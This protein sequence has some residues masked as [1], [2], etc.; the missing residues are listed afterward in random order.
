M[1]KELGIAI[2]AAG[3]GTRLRSHRAKVLFEI[4]GATLLEHVINTARMLVEAKDIHVIIGHQ[5]DIVRERTAHIGVKYVL[6]A[7]Q[8]G[9][10]HAIRCARKQLSQYKEILVLSGDAPLVRPETLRA[11][12]EQHRKQR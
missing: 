10:G 4:G 1:A 3:K 7:E 9:T 8:H 11:L 5:A 2:L 12:L 6:Q